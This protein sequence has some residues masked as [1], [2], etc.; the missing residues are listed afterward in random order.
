MSPD[1]QKVAR[2]VIMMIRINFAF[3][4]NVHWQTPLITLITNHER[5][6]SR[7]TRLPFICYPTSIR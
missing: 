3:L 2:L 1:V 5:A 7:R 4:E 6:A